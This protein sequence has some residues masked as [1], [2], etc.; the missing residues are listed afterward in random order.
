[1]AAEFPKSYKDPLYAEL[2]AKTERKL[3]LPSGL[4]VAIRTRGERSNADQVSEANAETPYQFIPSTRRAIVDKYGIDPLLSPANASEAAGLLLKESLDRNKG[5]ASIA[6]AEYHGG[7]NR[8]N[9]GPRTTA[10]VKR[11]VGA[12]PKPVTSQD[13]PSATINLPV[14]SGPSMFQRAQAQR[15]ADQPPAESIAKV[16]AAYQSGQMSPEDA[17]AFEADV[18]SGALMLPAGASVKNQAAAPQGIVQNILGAGETALT[19][20]TGAIGAPVGVLMG[21]GKTISQAAQGQPTTGEQNITQGMQALTYAPRTI[22]GQQQV[23]TASRHR[24][25][26]YPCHDGPACWRCGPG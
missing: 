16:Y 24:C 9:W 2:D 13:L 7:I 14:T 23:E 15:Q 18:S 6:V 10:Y 11:V 4:L 17:A 20:G 21:V 25:C 22:A 19:L 5:D 26:R 12:E 3:G 1:M 8:K